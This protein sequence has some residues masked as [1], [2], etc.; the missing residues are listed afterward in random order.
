MDPVELIITP[1][2]LK[3]LVS[4]ER[5]DQKRV[6]KALTLFAHNPSHPSLRLKKRT[7]DKLW[8]ISFSKSGRMLFDW[9]DERT[10]HRAI[11][12]AVGHHEIV[13]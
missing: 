3:Q 1:R 5:R 4:L 12:L 13:E 8:E 10:R 6:A 9:D 2:F 11:F 7:S